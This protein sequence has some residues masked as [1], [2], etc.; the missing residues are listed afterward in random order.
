MT[1][2]NRIECGKSGGKNCAICKHYSGSNFMP[3]KME[4][5]LCYYKFSIKN[6][7]NAVRN[8]RRPKL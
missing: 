6:W 2:K 5:G 4:Q 1:I 7:F 3:C 8:I